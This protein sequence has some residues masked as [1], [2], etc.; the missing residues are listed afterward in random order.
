MDNGQNGDLHL[1]QISECDES[2]TTSNKKHGGTLSKRNSSSNTEVTFDIE[3]DDKKK[4]T[5]KRCVW[6]RLWCD[7][8]TASLRT[9]HNPLPDT[10]SSCE[11]FKFAFLCPPHGRVGG[12]MFLLVLFFTLW[13]VLVA[14]T[15]NEA[16]PGGNLFSL[17]VLFFTCWFGGYLIS[18]LRLPPLLGKY[19]RDLLLLMCTEVVKNSTLYLQSSYW[20]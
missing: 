9:D 20:I 12:F 8:C 16:L 17:L 14:I 6:C 3:D 1:Q 19:F 18:F 10:P 13:G 15:D 11:R 2:E 4:K 5:S 7:R